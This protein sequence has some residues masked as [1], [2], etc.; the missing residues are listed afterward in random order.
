MRRFLVVLGLGLAACNPPP[1]PPS[2]DDRVVTLE[3]QNK[4]FE[5]RLIQ[6]ERA[7]AEVR[8]T[9]DRPAPLPVDAGAVK[10]PVPPSSPRPSSQLRSPGF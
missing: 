1:P 3:K 4:A 2:A 7:L 10:A 5:E 9:I 8:G 6:L